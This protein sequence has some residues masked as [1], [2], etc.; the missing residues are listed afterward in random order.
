MARRH[1]AKER[2]DAIEVDVAQAVRACR[3]IDLSW[4][5]I[6][7]IMNMTEDAVTKRHGEH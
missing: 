2:L 3:S 4:A 7:Q 5:E 6:A 1:A